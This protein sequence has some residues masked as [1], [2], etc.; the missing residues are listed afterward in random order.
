MPVLRLFRKAVL[1]AV[2]LLLCSAAVC[3]AE[4]SQGRIKSVAGGVGVL[5]L[6]VD[7]GD[8]LLVNWDKGTVWENL[9][10]PA[11][12]LSG[13]VLTVDF[14]RKGDLILAKKITKILPKV[15]EGVKVV[16]LEEIAR[17]LDKPGAAVPFT[18]IDTRPADRY[19]V[20]HL[21]GAVSVP[22]RRIEKRSAGILP[23]DRGARLVFYDDGP[24]DG[25][26]GRAAELT[27]KAGYANVAVFPD[28]TAAWERSGRFLA[29]SSAYLRK[30]KGVIIDLRDP[31]RV[32]AGHIEHAVSIPAADLAT[33][34][35][36]F[37]VQRRI[38]FILYGET[39]AEAL[40]A[41]RT[42]RQWGYRQITIYSGGVK[43]W[44]ESAEVLTTEKAD[45]SIQTAV[46]S[47]G[48]ALRPNDFEHALTSTQTV[49]VVD[50]RSEGEQR[51]GTFPNSKR[52]PLRE[53]SS[54]HGELNR[55]L[56]QVVFG[57]DAEQ[58]E[59]ATDFLRSKDYRVNYLAGG[60][61][62]QGEGKYLVK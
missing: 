44:V 26:A 23:E 46:D 10:S 41:A 13:E 39:D 62:F 16:P 2:A 27:M 33:R 42:L 1:P 40:A 50:V 21:P 19:E 9:K 36:L 5:T 4:V 22:L 56:I 58:A 60:V 15:P 34:F 12:L 24:G 49:E 37:P 57:S 29:S 52:I 11:E 55:E 25:S 7:K 45:Q 47:R 38:P 17:Y 28:G 30:G 61:E 35:G 48:G 53:L 20:A 59:M 18:L 51:T 31:A 32:D 3:P 54:R 14:S 8:I 6:T 43:A